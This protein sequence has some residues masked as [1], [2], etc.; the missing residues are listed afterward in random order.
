MA[1]GSR[2]T[3][4]LTREQF[5]FI[6]D[7]FRDRGDTRLEL[8]C[9]LLARCIRV[10]CVLRV[11]KIESFFTP[12]WTVRDAFGWNEEK[13]G[14]WRLEQVGTSSRMRECL[15]R[16][17]LQLRSLPRD[18]GMFYGEKTG[19]VLH[20]KGVKK[21][22]KAF[23]G[24]RGIEQCSP[25]SF[26]KY[27]GRYLYFQCGVDIETISQLMNHSSVRETRTYLD[28]KP[29]ELARAAAQLVV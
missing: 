26:R 1:T 10:G 25:H 3:T 22:L 5:F 14:K 21:L 6:L 20:D 12:D 17:S 7:E 13:T 28:I 29:A 16:H 23:V 15:E 19:L 24:R 27:G 4:A 11:L 2:K 8:V 18:A 9:L